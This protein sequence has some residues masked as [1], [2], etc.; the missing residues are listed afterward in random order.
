M[1]SR[2]APAQI[3][4]EDVTAVILACNEA[5]N[6]PLTLATLPPGMRALVIDHE[7]SDGTG[8]LAA[9]LGAEVIVRPFAGFVAARRFALANV[10]TRW[11]LMIDADERLDERLA[12]A[13]VD[14]PGDADGYEVR[15]NTLYCGKALRMWRGEPLLRL[16]KTGSAQPVAHPVAGGTAELHESWHCSGTVCALAGTLVHDSYPSARSY[17][18]KFAR[19]T[20]VEAQGVRFSARAL[21]RDV[22][23]AP[24]R[25]GWYLFAKGALLDGG[26]GVRIAWRSAWYRAAVQ[27]KSR[28]SP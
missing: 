26:A 7:S 25:F 20:A 1:N 22:L 27:W 11:T 13:I 15:R 28:Q 10:R 14:A 24:L 16:F 19:Y 2:Q 4:P 18:E 21:A 5:R 12:R 6:L 3:N 9:Q 17:D 8:A 23:E